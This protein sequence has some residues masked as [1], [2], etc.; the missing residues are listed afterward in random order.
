MNL[1]KTVAIATAAGA[2]AAISVP[3]MALEN[4]F[5]GMFRSF[6]Y[7]SNAYSGGSAFMLQNDL[8]GRG[9]SR[10]TEQRAR[11]Q[12]TAKASDDL[13]LVTHFELDSRWGG[14]DIAGAGNAPKYGAYNDAGV[15]DADGISLE[16][17]QVYLD[18]N[19]PLTG[20]N[21]KLGI[22]PFN[23]AYQGTFGNWDGAGV[24]I[25]RK[26][27]AL[28]GTVAYFRGVDSTLKSLA[29]TSAATNSNAPSVDYKKS[30]DIYVLD[31]KYAVNKDLTVGAN[32]YAVTR[33]AALFAAVGAT[34]AP[35]PGSINT[36][37]GK[38][39]AAGP[40]EFT[41]MIGVNADAKVG[42]A[43]LTAA[44][45]Y[46]FGDF[47][48][49]RKL[50]AF[51]GN[52]TAKVAV[53]PGKVNASVLYLSGQNNTKTTGDYE[54]WQTAAA[55]VTYFN[56]SNMWLLIRNGATINTSTSPSATDIANKGMG[57]RGIFAG[58]EGTANKIFYNA[59]I[60]YA[61]VDKK[62][63]AKS[64]SIGTELN[65]TAGYKLYD[66]LTVGLT[67]AYLILGDGMNKDT[68]NST[69]PKTD[70]L[71]GMGLSK[72]DNPWMSTVQFNYTF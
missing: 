67:A 56:A 2:L 61:Q 66:N 3:A 26:F 21:V 35:A 1:K 16:T 38:F 40:A 58:Y 70:L 65:A 63:A 52:A 31:G 28:T 55:A 42:P 5:N 15:L 53:G 10:F 20:S 9:T 72:A 32:Y 64:A 29:V 44:L 18:F 22:Q 59:N 4:Q 34:A 43:A 7:L 33:D 24:Q 41:N 14:N 12:Y 54:G 50:S 27:N 51:G 8:T 36:A 46:Q 17:K 11:L 71:A 6:S 39:N 23:D 69:T 19:C 30:V 45:G 25:S 49:A 37:A 13:K 68:S 48:S 47:N 57:M 62:G 60:G